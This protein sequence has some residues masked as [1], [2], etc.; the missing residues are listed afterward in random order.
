MK[1]LDI[2][3]ERLVELQKIK[4]TFEGTH[5][6]AN[7]SSIQGKISELITISDMT[8]SI[9]TVDLEGFKTEENS[10]VQLVAKY[11]KFFYR[12]N[13]RKI[14]DENEFIHAK[15]VAQILDE[16][17]AS[18]EAIC[19]GF[20]HDVVEDT[21]YSSELMEI[22]F[23][24]FKSGNSEYTI[25]ELV[26][27]HTED[28]LKSWEDRKQKTIDEVA[29]NVVQEGIWLI[30]S[31]RIANME[32]IIES[33]LTYL[34]EDLFWDNFKRGKDKQFWYFKNIFDNALNQKSKFPKLAEYEKLM[35][36]IF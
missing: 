36:E 15:R 16:S 23:Q 3:F 4:K 1:S 26:A 14:S 8:V 30:L 12:N 11:A 35:L 29:E 2:I 13:F 33:N 31:D 21:P 24:R 6:G 19:A 5:D 10:V 25:P 22:L 9:S 20:L 7:L 27:F 34:S 17:D 28:K 18:I 32:S